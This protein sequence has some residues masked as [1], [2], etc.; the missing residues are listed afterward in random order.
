MALG[1]GAFTAQ[2]K[3]LPG[4]YINFV[5]AARASANLSDRG[6][7]A[8]PLE[9]DWGPDG[10]VFEVTNSDFAKNALT[11]FGYDY[12]HAKLLNLREMFRNAKSV[13]CYRL[14][15]GAKA[16]NSYCT[17]KYTGI[18]GNDLKTVIATNAD[19]TTKFDVKTFVEN[20]VYDVQTVGSAAQLKDNAFV[21][22]KSDAELTATAGVGLTGGTNAVSVTGQNYADFLAKIES[23]TFNALGCPAKDEETINLF[24]AFTKRM[25]DEMGVKFQTVVP[26]MTA[27]PDYEGIIEVV[28]TV[29]DQGAPVSAVVYWLTGAEG[30]C[31]VN[32]SLTNCVYDGEYIINADYTQAELERFMQSGRLV[33][34]KVGKEIRVL[35]DLNS[36]IS[37]TD[38]KGEDFGSNQTIRVLDQIA[39]DVAQ[40]FNSRY[41]GTIPNNAGGRVSLWNDIVKHHQELEKLQAIEAFDPASVVVENGDSKRAVVV[42]D[43]V[44]PT[45][46]MAQLYMTVVVA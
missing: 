31:K 40:I 43:K 16:T 19:D 20:T 36:F 29:K 6:V 7:I 45:N 44:T 5:S 39:N 28:N 1:G 10:D 15:S 32:A 3:I 14:N 23:F 33:F 21:V 42:S 24:V 34:H 22:F 2:N 38:N 8:M 11:L 18:R 27:S 35:S 26:K 9:L 30:A 46:C 13:L 41:L 12:S 4:T 17:A 25:R 37:Y